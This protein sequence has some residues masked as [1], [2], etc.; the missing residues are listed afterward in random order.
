MNKIIFLLIAF[1]SIINFCYP[2][3]SESLL[4]SSSV[5]KSI[6]PNDE[7]YTDLLPLK[8]K[9]DEAQIVVLGEISHDG[10]ATLQAKSRFVKFLH[11][12]MGFEVIAWEAGFIDCYY[13]NEALRSEFPLKDAKKYMM[14]GSWEASEYVH[15]VFDYAR[16]SW[17]TERPLIMAGFDL[18]RP[19]SAA[20]NYIGVI[21]S[22]FAKAPWLK[23]ADSVYSK[24]DTCAKSVGGYLGNQFTKKFSKKSEQT[25]KFF[26]YSLMDSLTSDKKSSGEF[27]QLEKLK[28]SYFLRSFYFDVE[29]NNLIY[30][31]DETYQ[32]MRDKFMADR[33]LW[34]IEKL[35]PGK[36][37]IV[38]ASTAHFKRNS[39]LQTRIDGDK[40][41]GD[42]SFYNR[43]SVFLQAG[44]YLDYYFGKKIYTIA[45]TTFQGEKGMVFPDGHPKKK[46]YEYTDK[47]NEPE[48]GSYEAI[49]HE[50]EE[51]YLFTDLRSLRKNNWLSKEYIAYPVGYRK[52]KARWND[53]IDAFFFIDK[54][55]PEKILPIDK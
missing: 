34:L 36:K 50:T 44:D 55:F 24:I 46:D 33:M 38:W 19:P 15:P 37:I 12:E 7:D 11:K 3:T 25:V 17:K 2:Q 42:L 13:M 48:P 18:G 8:K 6:D 39:F 22:I 52:V 54:M 45:F 26:I 27:S 23:P 40:S 21:D 28:Y 14:S 41:I 4:R 9:I 31:R 20:K 29:L 47:I 10:G 53:I 30:Q 49:A 51:E 35:Y 32:T 1:F 16:R 43:S 5:I